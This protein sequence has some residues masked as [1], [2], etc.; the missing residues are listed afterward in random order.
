MRLLECKDLNRTLREA[1]GEPVPYDPAHDEALDYDER[2]IEH[3]ERTIEHDERTIEHDERTIEHDERTIEH[4]EVF[5]KLVNCRKDTLRL[6]KKYQ[7]CVRAYSICMNEKDCESS[8][9]ATLKNCVGG[10]EK[11]KRPEGQE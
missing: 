1:L 6:Q 9:R 5:K 11:D 10:M 4:D 2:T 3:D 8:C 7:D